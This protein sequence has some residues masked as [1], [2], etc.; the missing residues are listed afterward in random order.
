MSKQIKKSESASSGFDSEDATDDRFYK[1]PSFG[2]YD[3]ESDLN[4]SISKINT[5][6]VNFT[7]RFKRPFK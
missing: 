5:D 3:K 7:H 1:I 4:Q 6:R 2:T